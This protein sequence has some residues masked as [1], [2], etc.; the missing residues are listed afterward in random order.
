MEDEV[1]TKPKRTRKSKPELPPHF[2]LHYRD[3]DIAHVRVWM[4]GWA[5]DAFE[6]IDRAS[7]NRFKVM[8]KRFGNTPVYHGQEDD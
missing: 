1:T 8:L 6:V 2:E 5:G 3:H 4:A 7:W